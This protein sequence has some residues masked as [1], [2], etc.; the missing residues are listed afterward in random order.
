MS[1]SV[2]IARRI[3]A[4]LFATAHEDVFDAPPDP[5][6]VARYLAAPHL[7][8]AVAVDGAQMIGMCSGVVYHHP[9]KPECYWINELAVA[10]PW[11][12]QGIATRLIDVTCGHARRLG[13][14][15]AWVLADPTEEAMAF[16]RSLGWRQTGTN[17]AMFTCDLD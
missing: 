6:L 15:E 16:Y 12:R 3:D 13:C 8:I 10:G 14:R 9:D 4:S 17:L 7:H 2:F 1:V 11:R 5:D